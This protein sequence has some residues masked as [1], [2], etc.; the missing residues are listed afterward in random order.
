MSRLQTTRWSLIAAAR[1]HP[2]KARNA[3]EQLCQTYRPPVLAFV[4][5]SGYS[6]ADAEDLTQAFFLRF[7]ERGWYGEADPGRGRFRSLLLTV[8]R[9]FLLDH[10][11]ATHAGKRDVTRTVE[12]DELAQSGDRGESPEQAFTRVWMG[13]VVANAYA[14]LEQEWERA[15]KRDQFVQLS[16]L[17][18]ERAESAELHALAAR[19]GQRPNTLCV[20]TH[21]MRQRLRQLVRLE[22]LQTVG[23]REALEEE[24]AELRGVLAE[25]D[26]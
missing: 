2:S 14:R 10:R 15:G 24:L 13:T 8:L 12:F 11:D 19:L 5:R 16:P 4:R 21:R 23:S 25:A 17:L 1:D 22:L 3:L 7:I 6:Q 26:G 9:R 18:T 20:Q